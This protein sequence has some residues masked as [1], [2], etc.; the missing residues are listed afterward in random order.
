MDEITL[1]KF[2]SE[3]LAAEMGIEDPKILE[4]IVKIREVVAGTLLMKEESNEVD[5]FILIK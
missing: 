2:A 4:G 3:A 5:S 1:I